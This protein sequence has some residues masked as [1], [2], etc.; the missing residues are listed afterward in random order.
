MNGFF[1]PRIQK[2]AIVRISKNLKGK[3]KILVSEN[4]QVQP[5]DIIGSA[6]ISSGF[7][8]INLAKELKVSATEVG[9]YLKR[10]LGQRIYKG[11]LL[12]EKQGFLTGKIIVVSPTD[13]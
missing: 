13:G 2:D 1:R 5:S 7:R 10:P 3:G 9:K 6:Q 11:E 12:A 8:I 4:Q